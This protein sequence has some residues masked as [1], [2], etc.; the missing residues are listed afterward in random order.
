MNILME[1][2][3]SKR[4]E[5]IRAFKSVANC[6]NNLLTQHFEA[7]GLTASQGEVLLCLYQ[8]AA[9]PVQTTD[10]LQIFQISPSSLSGTLR[11][12]EE[13]GYISYAREQ[14]DNRRKEITLTKKA[15]S[16][17]TLLETKMRS[18]ED[19]VYQEIEDSDC[20]AVHQTLETILQN[21]ANF[22]G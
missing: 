4:R 13:K 1:P 9:F 18:L 7:L 16:A 2:D 8:T 15:I 19:A 14:E 22:D 17:Q 5:L 12:L 3:Y 11:K 6:Y 10:L 20:I 21:I